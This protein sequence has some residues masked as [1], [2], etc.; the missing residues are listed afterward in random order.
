MTSPVAPVPVYF[1]ESWAI[2]SSVCLVN[3][4][5]GFMVVGITSLTP[6]SI[7]PIVVRKFSIFPFYPSA[8]LSDC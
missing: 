4:L 3:V 7:V 6:V 8:L 1:E 2:L 5:F